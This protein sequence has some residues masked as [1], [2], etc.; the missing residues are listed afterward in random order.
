MIFV[1]LGSQKFQFNRLLKKLDELVEKGIIKEEIFAQIGYSDYNPKN[2]NFENFIDR[3]KFIEVMDKCDKVITHGGTGAIIG[4]IKK[5]KKVIAI[6][7]N[8]EFNEHVDNHQYDIV[9]EFSNMN[10]IIGIDDLEDIEKSIKKIDS[11]IFKNYETN[12]ENIILDIEKFIN[13]N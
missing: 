8:C 12:T 4:A 2:Y 6:P 7:R 5:N 9:S 13:I 1:T 11:T 3:N 10:L